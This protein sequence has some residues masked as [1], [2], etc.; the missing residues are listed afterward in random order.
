MNVKNILRDQQGEFQ[1]IIHKDNYIEREFS[2]NYDSHH[3]SNLIKTIVG[4]R[5][6]GKS[7]FTA[8]MLSGKS[9]GYVNFDERILLD[10]DPDD[11]LSIL[12]ELKGD[13]KIVFFDEIQNVDGWELF[14]NKMHRRGYT[15]FLTGSSS[16]LL[17]RELATHLT[18]R[19]VSLEIFPFSF[20]EYLTSKKIS[21]NPETTG[22][23]NLIKHQLNNYTDNGGFPDVVNGEN[24]GHYLK[25][26]YDDIVEKDIISRFNISYKST[27]R[28]IAM[29]MI[30]NAGKYVSYNKIKND[31][32]LKSDHTAKNY[33]SYLEESYL[34]LQLKKFS[35]KPKEIEKSTKKIYCIDTGMINHVT[36]GLT[37]NRG[38]KMENVVYIDLLRRRNYFTENI[39]I[40]YFKDYNDHEVDFVIKS[41]IE[42]KELINVTYS[43]NRGDVEKREIK[44]LVT[45]STLLHCTKLTLIT[46]NYE[47]VISF[48]GS[49]IDAIP[50]WKWLLQ[51]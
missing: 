47:D 6:S 25:N 8:S 39:E 15:V 27:F 43:E 35:F 23:E 13:F 3:K 26:L 19:H 17:S 41:G 45:A 16:K 46:W 30:G 18:G 20:R 42:V 32:G 4:V 38:S 28:E 7:T 14:V 9:V 37:E 48:E 1:H 31:F 44:S 11:I 22:D 34:I 5:R 21:H 50:L 24:P 29:T 51:L 2:N 40:Y 36:S 33:L 49:T 10:V 12:V